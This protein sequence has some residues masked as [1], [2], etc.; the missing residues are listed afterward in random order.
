MNCHRPR[1][2]SVKYDKCLFLSALVTNTIAQ[3]YHSIF[4]GRRV[5]KKPSQG[6]LAACQTF[7]PKNIMAFLYYEVVI[8]YLQLL[9]VDLYLLCWILACICRAFSLI[10][11]LLVC[12]KFMHDVI[13][14][15]DI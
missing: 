3:D 5:F 9:L 12:K 11:Q 2:K 8:I 15:S 1:N 7:Q 14:F 10:S 4:V 13:L 6:H